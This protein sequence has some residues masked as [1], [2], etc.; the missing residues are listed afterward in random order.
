MTDDR[1]TIDRDAWGWLLKSAAE[2]VK[3]GPSE[4]LFTTL[5]VAHAIPALLDALGAETRRA[6]AAE[7]E[8]ARLTAEVLDAADLA[9]EAIIEQRDAARS[10]R[11]SLGERI[12]AVRAL[13]RGL[14][15]DSLIDETW[16]EAC[17]EGDPTEWSCATIRALDE[18]AE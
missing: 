16:C 9:D 15:P 3:E 11:D 10:E 18:G 1:P 14:T 8:M 12:A 17:C 6:D 5:E 13:H 7:A 4:L 2:V